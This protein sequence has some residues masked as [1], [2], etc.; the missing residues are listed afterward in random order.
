MHVDRQA[1]ETGLTGRTERTGKSALTNDRKH[2]QV[3]RQA[4]ETV[5]AGGLKGQE[6]RW[7]IRMGSGG[8]NL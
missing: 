7:N 1:A 6:S 5:L 2:M 4:V 3:D 8:Y